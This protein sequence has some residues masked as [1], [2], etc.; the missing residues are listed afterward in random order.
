MLW[1]GQ[2]NRFSKHWREGEEKVRNSGQREGIAEF[3]ASYI[4]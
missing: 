3:P 1:W 4:L 2:R